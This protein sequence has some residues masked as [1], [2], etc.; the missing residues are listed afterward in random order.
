MSNLLNV[1]NALYFR[2]IVINI[3]MTL[4]NASAPYLLHMQSIFPLYYLHIS[5]I[6]PPYFSL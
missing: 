3:S 1:L 5:S 4:P 6:L 2:A